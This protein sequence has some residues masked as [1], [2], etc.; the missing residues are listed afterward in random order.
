MKRIA[1]AATALTAGLILTGCDAGP[2]CLKSHTQVVP[3]TTVVNGKA[4]V[5]TSVVVICTEYAKE[6]SK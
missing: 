5:T 4:V 6:E 3:S 2:E 1:V